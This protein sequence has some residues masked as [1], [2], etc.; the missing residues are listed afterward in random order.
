MDTKIIGLIAGSF[1]L[2]GCMTAKVE[3]LHTTTSQLSNDVDNYVALTSKVVD[4]KKQSILNYQTKDTLTDF[5]KD[6]QINKT[7]EEKNE[8]D[9]M[10]FN[11]SFLANYKTY[12]NGENIKQQA[13]QISAYFKMLPNTLESKDLEPK[14]LNLVKNI[15]ILNK[16]IEGD[17]TKDSPELKGGL[18]PIESD[19]IDKL[20][21]EGYKVYEYKKFQSLMDLQYDIVLQSI[22][23]L[24]N[25]TS[26]ALTP[27]ANKLDYDFETSYKDL[28]TSF[29]NQHEMAYK[30]NKNEI[31]KVQYSN[32]D[33]KK[34][35]DLFS[36]PEVINS[37]VNEYGLNNKSKIFRS[38]VYKTYCLNNEDFDNTGYSIKEFNDLNEPKIVKDNF[39]NLKNVIFIKG[40]DPSCELIDILGH[41]K[42]KNYNRID[43]N[44]FKRANKDFE[45]VIN[46]ML[47]K[48]PSEDKE[49]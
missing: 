26:V 38:E 34:L 21:M 9:L 23:T 25:Y 47:K 7:K 30:K 35:N 49:K 18:R 11:N 15:D 13:S 46:F 16:T 27:A 8:E 37:V 3:Q 1:F 39:F 31:N 5:L 44:S 24:K 48:F 12:S 32:D 41:L 33:L 6:K 45:S 43:L 28:F 2:T 20:F 29:L 36:Q 42:E 40:N 19:L 17:L 22:I 4:F 14:F 10:N